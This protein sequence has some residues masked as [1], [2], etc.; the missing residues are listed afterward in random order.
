MGFP[1]DIFSL[2]YIIKWEAIHKS[3]VPKICLVLLGFL[4]VLVATTFSYTS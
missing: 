2:K 1:R 3:T 4:I